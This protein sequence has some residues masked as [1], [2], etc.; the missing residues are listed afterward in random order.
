MNVEKIFKKFAHMLGKELDASSKWLEICEDALIEIKTQIKDKSDTK[1]NEDRLN[2]AAAA[3]AF[4]KYTLC[5]IGKSA[6]I[7]VGE[8]SGEEIINKRIVLS[9]AE[10]VWE[11]ARLRIIDLLKDSE[12]VFKGVNQYSR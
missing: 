12:F 4:Y 1:E 10:T 8:F 2:K 5:L 6:D 11:N 3:L 7:A 9:S